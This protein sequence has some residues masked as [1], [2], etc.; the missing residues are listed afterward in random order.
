MISDH[1]VLVTANKSRFSGTP[2]PV[3]TLYIVSSLACIGQWW[4]L[5][6]VS[7]WPLPRLRTDWFWRPTFSRGCVVRGPSPPPACHQPATPA[8]PGNAHTL[9]CMNLPTFYIVILYTYQD[10][11]RYCVSVW[12]PCVYFLLN[13]LLVLGSS[14]IQMVLGG[15]KYDIWIVNSKQSLIRKWW[16]TNQ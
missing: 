15:L 3:L 7:L 13:L 6:V 12:Y 4:S 1:P 5:E 11:T 9:H 10:K 14:Q 16:G 2:C 8:P